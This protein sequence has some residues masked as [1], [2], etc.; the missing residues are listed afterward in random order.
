MAKSYEYYL[1]IEFDNNNDTVIYE[2]NSY[3]SSNHTADMVSL[4]YS[5][6]RISFTRTYKKKWEDFR[7][8]KNGYVMNHLKKALCCYMLAKG[9]IPE[10]RAAVFAAEDSEQELYDL[11]NKLNDQSGGKL[12]IKLRRPDFSRVFTGDTEERKAL[13][14]SMTFFI[15]SQLS[16][17]SPHDSMR[18]AWS[19]LNALYTEIHRTGKEQDKLDELWEY[20]PQLNMN[21]TTEYIIGFD[22]SVWNS[23]DWEKYVENGISNNDRKAKFKRLL[24]GLFA[25]Q[26]D[27]DSLLGGLLFAAAKEKFPDLVNN[28]T[29]SNVKKRIAFMVCRYCY[30]K[31]NMSMHAGMPY[32][33]YVFSEKEE[34]RTENI[35]VK[36]LNYTVRDI[37]TERYFCNNP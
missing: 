26:T 6:I 5:G 33:L 37:L 3:I 12:D 17:N 32:P 11:K 36:I 28:C 21:K 16:G 22:D 9:S 2:G 31:R 23:L 35:L 18:A 1:E 29:A 10:C 25:E 13:Y 7:D 15:H 14:N 20:I 19:S 34:S 8:Q 27:F 30:F 4:K 24:D